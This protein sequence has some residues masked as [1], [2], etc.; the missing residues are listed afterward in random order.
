M[1]LYI[2]QSQKDF[3]FYIGTTE[4]LMERLKEHNK[5]LST[6]TRTKRPWILVYCEWYR[7]KTDCLKRE[8]QL[9]KHKMGWRKIKE[10][11]KNSCMRG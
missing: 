10:R 1:Y 9:K 2:V 5:G 3:S 6:F 7:S 11:I 4:R 8:R